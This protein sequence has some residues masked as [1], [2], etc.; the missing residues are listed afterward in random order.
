MTITEV[1]VFPKSEEKLKA[2]AAVT[3]D[4][5]FVVHNLR[6]V[7]GEKGLMVCMPS[8]KKNDG[9][10]KD[11]AHPITNEFRSELEKIVLAAYDKKLSEAPQ[12]QQSI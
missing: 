2:Y 1:R 5:V 8:K 9:T 10:F 11:I 7:K 3:F 4:N 6:I 12:E